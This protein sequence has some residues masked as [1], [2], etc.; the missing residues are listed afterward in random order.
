[1]IDVFVVFKSVFL[2]FLMIIPG[3]LMRKLKLADGNLAK[4]FANTILFVTQPALIIVSF[5]RDFDMQVLY[6]AAGVLAFSFVAHTMYYII[7]RRCFKKTTL[8]MRKVLQFASIFSNAGYMGIPL[9]MSIIDSA[10]GIYA[11]VYI[12]GF[13]VFSWS[14]GCLIY[15]EDKSYISAKKIFINPATIPTY[16]GLLLFL[17]PANRLVPTLLVDALEML[18]LTV[19][20]M[21]MMMIG[22]RLAE[23]K[24][25]GVL[26]DVQLIKATVMRLILFPVLLWIIM[27]GVAMVGL[28]SDMTAMTVC[29]ICSAT[30]SA[31]S[32]GIFAE[33]FS[34][35][36]A[37]ASKVVSVTTILS[38]ITMPLVS[39][40]LKV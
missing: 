15:S 7:A 11:S 17:T 18:K 12:I 40:L 39:L 31:T 29:L 21:S 30:P 6:I 20:P 4:G 26:R 24:W 5:I 36:T 19:A 37:Y 9:I 27:K 23:A 10:A 14:L 32:A 1:M 38:L 13:N 35:D 28:Y 2:L 22:I 33:K 25:K 34:G 8:E 3:F 16:I